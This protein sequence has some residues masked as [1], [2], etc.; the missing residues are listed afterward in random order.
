MYLYYFLIAIKS[1]IEK[2]AGSL[3]RMKTKRK[4]KEKIKKTK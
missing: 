1:Y 2:L 3:L 4:N